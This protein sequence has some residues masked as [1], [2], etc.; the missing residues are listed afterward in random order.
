MSEFFVHNDRQTAARLRVAFR[1]A[2]RGAARF[3][4][5][6]CLRG[7]DKWIERCGRAMGL[8]LIGR[9]LNRYQARLTKKRESAALLSRVAVTPAP[10]VHLLNA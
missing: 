6:C 8:L 1:R 5:L 10:K 7:K 3:R 9:R 2:K 4:I